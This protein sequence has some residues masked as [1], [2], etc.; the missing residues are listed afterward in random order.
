[1]ERGG[2]PGSL[3][4]GPRM[5]IADYYYENKFLDLAEKEYQDILQQWPEI[6]EA[7][8]KMGSIY[9]RQNQ[10]TYAFKP[11]NGQQSSTRAVNW[12]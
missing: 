10:L 11:L 7:H 5:A 12:Q 8:F 4:P 1:M 9:Y 6:Q 2:P 3:K